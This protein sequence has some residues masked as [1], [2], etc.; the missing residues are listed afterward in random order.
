MLVVW[1]N[2]SMWNTK[3]ELSL[4]LLRVEETI[5]LFR[6]QCRVFIWIFYFLLFSSLTMRSRNSFFFQLQFLMIFIHFDQYFA[7]TKAVA[8]IFQQQYC[9]TIWYNLSE[10][11]KNTE[12]VL[13]SNHTL[14]IEEIVWCKWNSLFLFQIWNI[15]SIKRQTNYLTNSVQDIWRSRKAWNNLIENIILLIN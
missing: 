2:F 6:C 15:W 1:D 12:P 14:F 8:K 11:Q 9:N 4:F 7:G 10:K 5:Y 3:L 13:F